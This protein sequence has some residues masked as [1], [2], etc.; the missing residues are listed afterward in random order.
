MVRQGSS[1]LARWRARYG[2]TFCISNRACAVEP[3]GPAT[4]ANPLPWPRGSRRECWAS[5][6]LG[7]ETVVPLVD[8]MST[9]LACGAVA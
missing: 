3:R 2:V 1:G 6:C 5:Y 9:F 8:S 4:R 7:A